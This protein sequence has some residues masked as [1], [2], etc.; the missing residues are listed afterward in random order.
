MNNFTWKTLATPKEL[1]LAIFF[2]ILAM[3]SM[4]YIL[5]A[6]GLDG[7]IASGIA[8]API[9]IYLYFRT[10]YLRKKIGDK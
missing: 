5:V 9:P 10:R 3:V 7:D 1:V 8:P 2:S 4:K 6:L